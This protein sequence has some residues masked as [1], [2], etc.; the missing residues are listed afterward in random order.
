VPLENDAPGTPVRGDASERNAA[1]LPKYWPTAVTVGLVPPVPSVMIDVS[2]AGAWGTNRCHAS[3]ASAAAAH[4]QVST[5]Q[6][7]CLTANGASSKL[8]TMPKFPPPPPRSAQ[9]R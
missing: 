6:L 4:G 7:A 9:N 5:N 2:S 3:S 1:S 8:V